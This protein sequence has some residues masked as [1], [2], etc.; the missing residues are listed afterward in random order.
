MTNNA[1]SLMTAFIGTQGVSIVKFDNNIVNMTVVA[2]EDTGISVEY[3][4]PNPK[5]T[6]FDSIG[7][8][9][10]LVILAGT[11]PLH[12]KRENINKTAKKHA[13]E[14]V[15]PCKQNFGQ[16]TDTDFS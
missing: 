14:G 6:K 5:T 3:V 13:I 2:I 7:N 11:L 10:K 1:A 9:S 12:L 16:G 15:I 4:G 8:R